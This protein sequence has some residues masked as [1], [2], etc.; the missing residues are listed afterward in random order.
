MLLPAFGLPT[1]PTSA[2]T[3]SSKS[4]L[5]TSPSPPGVCSRGAVGRR[6]EMGVAIAAAAAAGD[7]DLLADLRQ[8]FQEKLA[9]GVVDHGAGGNRQD[10]IRGAA[11]VAIAAGAGHAILGPPM[12][13][14][15][16]SS[17]AI[18]ARLGHENDA[19][20]VAAVAA[21]GPAAGMNFSRRK[22]RQ[23]LPPL[24]AAT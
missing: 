3:F 21:V 16:Q 4:R 24:P 7:D 17:E 14:M 19:A 15:G 18:D 23:P 10:Q 1:R 9:V 5:R 20:A 8:V 2:I 11:A 22:L 12:F 13:A 6:F